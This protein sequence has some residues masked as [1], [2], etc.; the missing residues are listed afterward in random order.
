MKYLFIL[1][2]LC[3]FTC[4]AGNGQDTP[5]ATDIVAEW[6]PPE[7]DRRKY[8]NNS[9]HARIEVG[10]KDG[11]ETLDFI[12]WP[13]LD[14]SVYFNIDLGLNPDRIE[15]V[16]DTTLIDYPSFDLRFYTID[17]STLEWEAILY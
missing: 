11:K 15:F 2:L 7:N 14:D 13:G 12:K 9:R 4:G 17:E 1:I 16:G 5:L 8:N 3:L 10:R 6:E